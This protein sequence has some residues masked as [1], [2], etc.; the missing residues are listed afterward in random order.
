MDEPDRRLL[1]IVCADIAGYSRLMS[2]DEDGTFAR[3]RSL[4]ADVVTPSA[5]RHHGRIVK[6]MGDGFL[7][8]FGSAIQAVGF[9]VEVQRRCK[10]MGSPLC[11]R[12]GIHAG[13]VIW[14]NGDV[15]GD[16][17]NIAAR[18]QEVAEPGGILVS[19]H[20]RDHARDRF[21]F[22]EAGER[23]LKNIS[24]P[25]RTFRVAGQPRPRRHSP[26]ARLLK[27][28][29]LPI[30]LA[31]VLLLVTG[32][33]AFF[34]SGPFP[35]R[36]EPQGGRPTIA[37]LPFANRSGDPEQDYFSD[38]LTENVLTAL[39]RFPHLFVVSRNSTFSYKG[40]VI[41]LTEVGRTLGVRY[42][43]EGSVQKAGDQ[44]RV[45][46]QLSDTRGGAQIW[47]ER[48]DRPL[49]EIFAIQDE[50]A[51]RIAARLGAT[52]QRAEVA[53]GLRKPTTDL[54][55]YDYYLR[56]R[57]LRQT[58]RRDKAI[59]ARTLFE[60]AV[61]LD[62]LFAPAIAELAFS[63]YRE[64]ALRW[65]PP[66]REKVLE[67][68]L[69][70][71]ERALAAEPSLPLAHMVMGDL[72]LRRLSHDEAIRWARR[73]VELNPSEA[74]Y[75]AGLANILTFAGQVEE[76]VSLMRRAFVLDP[77]HPPN[78]D[79]YLAR[80]LLLDRRFD[81]ALPHLRDCARRAP[82]Y[83]PCHLFSAVAYAHLGRAAEARSAIEDLR[84]NSTVRSIGGFLGTGEYLPG[85]HR[86]LIQEG[87]ANAGL[88][89]D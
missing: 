34:L 17:V 77:L 31:M 23:R 89:M 36:Q 56:G 60:K 6:T 41:D 61:E 15:F 44:I 42:A 52:I 12:I 26:P 8:E 51:E 30:G 29:A 47:A 10:E 86:D 25:V 67:R 73:A 22:E 21:P 74:E 28:R 14:T 80:A 59:E 35:W 7:A 3:L 1:A 75:H 50:I 55:A 37:V 82:D 72:L 87:L 19:R 33:A 11:F 16:G 78:Y 65:D 85:P 71:A 83:W 84:R 69:S 38:G 20:V 43:L 4:L 57:S 39:A 32:L 66:S 62:P 58:N 27:G 2:E 48:Y 24:R 53:A 46:A 54:T 88:P 76:A 79:M 63:D 68:G 13:D 5:A 45:S 18:L 40:K 64:V 81:E 9:A 70:Y 49:Q